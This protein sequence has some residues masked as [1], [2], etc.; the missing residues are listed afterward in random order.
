[1]DGAKLVAK[2]ATSAEDCCER[3]PIEKMQLEFTRLR[4]ANASSS[5]QSLMT[6]GRTNQT[7]CG[8]LC[9]RSSAGWCWRPAWSRAAAGCSARAWCCTSSPSAWPTAPACCAASAPA[10]PTSRR[11]TAAATAPRTPAARTRLAAG[12]HGP[13]ERLVACPST[14]WPRQ[15]RG[16]AA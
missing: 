5:A 4:R 8:P 9:S 14:P 2:P 3:Y 13:A 12:L 11:P 16:L 6:V 10:T 7:S 15:Q 1:M